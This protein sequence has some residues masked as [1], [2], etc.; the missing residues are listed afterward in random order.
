MKCFLV[1][2]SIFTL[3]NCQEKTSKSNSVL[4]KK[5]DNEVK[6]KLPTFMIYGEPYPV[7]YAEEQ[8]SLVTEKFG[9]KIKRVAGC[10]ISNVLKQSVINNNRKENQK[11]EQLFGK[12]WKE[13]FA[14]KS[15]L[16]LL[17]PEN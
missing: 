14:K 13:N 12:N 4:L 16:E 17:I 7:G 2:I 11:M 9:F 1:L 3:L 6:D 8:D 5:V 10:E 15:K